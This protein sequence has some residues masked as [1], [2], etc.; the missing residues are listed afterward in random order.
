MQ[1]KT[2]RFKTLLLACALASLACLCPAGSLKASSNPHAFPVPF[3]PSLGHTVIKFTELS[4]RAEVRIY[5]VAGKL[6]RTLYAENLNPEII[7]DVTN[8]QGERLASGIYLY[9]I[10]GGE[11]AAGKLIVIR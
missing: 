3:R 10:T 7:W 11:R 2:L 1:D 6:V 9:W 4:N 5:T 8:E